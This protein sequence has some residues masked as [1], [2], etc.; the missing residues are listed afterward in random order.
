MPR[1][2]RRAEW[3][4]CQN[5]ACTVLS[6]GHQR[7]FFCSSLVALAAAR[8]VHGWQDAVLLVKPATILRWH[9]EGSRHFWRWKSRKRRPAETK[10]SIEYVALIRRMA[11]DNCLL[12]AE[13]IRGEL[14]KL[15]ISMAK[16]TR[17]RTVSIFGPREP[18]SEFCE[19]QARR[20]DECDLRTL[21]WKRKARVSRPHH[22]C[23]ATPP[24]ACA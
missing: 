24:C 21:P 8:I 18:T 17:V 19:L 2:T 6:A 9:R 11:V 3:P 16:R 1:N 10:I 20:P 4:N 23:R 5:Q 22:H 12:G 14:L 7:L 13:R 15:G